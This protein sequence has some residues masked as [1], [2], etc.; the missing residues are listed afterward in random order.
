MT[1]YNFVNEEK[2]SFPYSVTKATDMI[3][4]ICNRNDTP[5]VVGSGNPYGYFIPV[6]RDAMAHILGPEISLKFTEAMQKPVIRKYYGLVTDRLSQVGINLAWCPLCW[7]VIKV[8][9]FKRTN[10]M[11]MLDPDSLYCIEDLKQ[12]RPAG[13]P[14][15]QVNLTL[16]KDAT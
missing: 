1:V 16:D 5:K 6:D 8:P 9:A 15:M 2:H 12:Q 14:R 4:A 7:Y 13:Q 11:G 10:I 3:V